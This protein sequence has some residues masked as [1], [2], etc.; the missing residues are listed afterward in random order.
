[1]KTKELIRQLQEI[2]PS[3]EL[4]CCISNHDILFVE[5][6]GAFYDGPLEILVRDTRGE[7][8]GGI[9]RRIGEKIRIHVLDLAGAVSDWDSSPALVEKYGRFPIKIEASDETSRRYLEQMVQSWQDAATSETD[10]S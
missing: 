3:G 6:I 9:L 10:A 1:M 2:D 4:E 5:R 7:V 8:V